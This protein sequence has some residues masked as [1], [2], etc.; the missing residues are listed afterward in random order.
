[1]IARR[2]TEALR[3]QNNSMRKAPAKHLLLFI[4]AVTAVLIS[5][6]CKKVAVPSVA[7]LDLDQAKQILTSAGLKVG[8][9]TGTQGPGT[10]VLTQSINPGVQVK[11][12]TAVD[13]T[14]EAPVQVPDLTKNKITDAVST[15]Q[16]SGLGVAFIKQP[17]LKLFGGAKVIAQTPLPTTLVHRGTVVTIT[18]SSPPDL[19]ALVGLVTKEPAYANLNPEYRNILDQFLK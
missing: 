9:I 6:G 10:Y 13:L 4:T 17:T 3:N 1:M 11:A 12:D 18:V 2:S 15:L 5:T 16:I 7:Q 8:N 14:V 19:G